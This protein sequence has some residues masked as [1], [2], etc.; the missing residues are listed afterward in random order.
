MLS[1]INSLPNCLIGSANNTQ[2][3]GHNATS[4]MTISVLST[5]GGSV[6]EG[7]VLNFDDE[8]N[9]IESKRSPLLQGESL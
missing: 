5:D 3:L 6:R 9:D 4:T 7:G 8:Y 2:Y 1:T